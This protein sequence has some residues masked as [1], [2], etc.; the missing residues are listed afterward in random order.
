MITT[1]G[2][3]VHPRQCTYPGIARSSSIHANVC[4][5]RS[6]GTGGGGHG[7][8][9]IGHAAARSVI[10]GL[11][12][13]SSLARR[14]PLARSIAPSSLAPSLGRRRRR[15]GV[16]G[17]PSSIARRHPLARSPARRRSPAAAAVA[18]AALGRRRRPP[19][20]ACSL[21]HPPPS[22]HYNIIK[23]LIATMPP[24]IYWSPV[25]RWL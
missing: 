8:C 4:I 24:C 9:M 12:S 20:V 17:P 22:L 21:A 11:E 14:R 18:R 15:S 1:E 16:L 25:C 23:L 2:C 13:P 3:P 10:G 7:A 6:N 19:A 5:V